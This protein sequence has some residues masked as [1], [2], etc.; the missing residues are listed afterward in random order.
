MT[1]TNSGFN[2]LILGIFVLNLGNFITRRIHVL[3]E[4]DIPP[5]VSKA[6]FH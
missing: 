3:E 1:F 6:V 5:P 4:Y 2:L